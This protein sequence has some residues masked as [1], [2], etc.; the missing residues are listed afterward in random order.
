MAYEIVEPFRPAEAVLAS[1]LEGFNKKPEAKK[2]TP[3]D[4]KATM[5]IMIRQFQA[6]ENRDK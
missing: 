2:Q 5:E 3:A 1:L 6:K 4:M